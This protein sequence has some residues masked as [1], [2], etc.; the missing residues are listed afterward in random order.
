MY[1]K[2]FIRSSWLMRLYMSA[3]SKIFRVGWQ[4]RDPGELML[5]FQF[6]GHLLENQEEPVL[7]MKST[8]HLLENS[9]LLKETGLFLIRLST[10]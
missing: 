8:G 6:R 4:A 3:K 1:L 7:H 2:R 9:L 10:D 5:Q